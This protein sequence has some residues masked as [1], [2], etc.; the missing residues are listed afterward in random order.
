[1]KNPMRFLFAVSLAISAGY[2]CALPIYA[3]GGNVTVEILKSNSGYSN[4]I[5]SY[6][7]SLKNSDATFIGVDDDTSVTRF[8]LGAFAA[9]TE[10]IF[11][12]VNENTFFTGD[13]SRNSDGLSHAL[14]ESVSPN[15]W[16]VSFEDLLGG[17]DLDYDDVV[18]HVTQ[19]A[20]P[21]PSSLALVAAGI[22]GLVLIRRKQA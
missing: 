14:I 13:T 5:Y 20:V 10:L 3:T 2:A 9:G 22:L 1:M 15:S 16:T 19:A 7:N 4:T 17:G 11:G 8:D 18:F 6:T 21:E 12:I